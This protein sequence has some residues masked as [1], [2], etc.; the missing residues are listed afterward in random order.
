V[1]KEKALLSKTKKLQTLV[2]KLQGSVNSNSLDPNHDPGQDGNG[3]SANHLVARDAMGY[4]L[5]YY[6]GDYGAINGNNTAYGNQDGSD[7]ATHSFDLFNGNIGRMVT[8]ITNPDSREAL[9]MGNAYKYDQLNRLREARSFTNYDASSNTWGS[10]QAALYYNAF[11]FD[12]NGNIE[13]QERWNAANQKIDQLQYKYKKNSADKL[14]RNR[15]YSV[16][17]LVDQGDFADDIDDMGFIAGNTIE[18]AN[19]YS[20]DQEGRLIKDVQ[21]EIQSI[22][23][24]VDGKVKKIIRPSGSQKKNVS[25]DYDA[26]GHRIAKHVM[27]ASNQL[28]KSTYYVLDAQGKSPWMNGRRR[29]AGELAPRLGGTMAVYEREINNTSNT[30]TFT[31]EEKHIYGSA[32]LGVMNDSIPLLGSQNDT[33]TQTT[34]VHTIG[35]RMYEL[36]N[37]LGNVLSVISDKVIPHVSTGTTVDYFLADI[38]QS[39]DY[40]PFGVTL[41]GR[42]FTTSGADGFRYGFQGQ[43]MD[44][45]IKGDGNSVN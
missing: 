35:K 38:R 30:I 32:R 4:S 18:T 43:E 34:W 21:E 11:T 15:L 42:N 19:N 6:D 41:Q 33:Y 1:D 2:R 28:E 27:N 31:Q 7:M 26:M 16:I 14:L 40:S 10:G 13:T 5:H 17:D 9:P 23:W 8:T 37:H 36:S 29:Q 22:E 3:L 44:D 24:S 12:A 39:T 25:F 45:E 20:Y